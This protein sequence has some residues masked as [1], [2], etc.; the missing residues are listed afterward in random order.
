MPLGFAA[1]NATVLV[2][3]NSLLYSGCRLMVQ[4]QTAG[5]PALVALALCQLA[6]AAHGRRVKCDSSGVYTCDAGTTCCPTVQGEL[7]LLARAFT[8]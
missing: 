8:V 4:P 2:A 1:G 7:L 3:W 6:A 5:R